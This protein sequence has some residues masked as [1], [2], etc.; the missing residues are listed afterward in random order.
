MVGS[1]ILEATKQRY[2]KASIF[3][4]DRKFLDLCSQSQVF[5][6]FKHNSFD[7]VIDC[8]AKVGG[9]HSNNKYR[10][11]F[12]YQNLQIQNNIIHACYLN[13]VKKLIFLGSSCVYPKN[14]PQPIKEESLLTSSLEYTNEPYA[15]AKIAGIKMCESYFKQYGCNF[16]SVMP[17]NLYGPKDSFHFENSHV[18]PS[19]MKKIHDA[20]VSNAESVSIWGTGKALREFMHVSDMAAACLDVAEKIDATY[21]NNHNISQINIGSGEEV[22]IAELVAKIAH[23]VGY[24]GKIIFDS[25]KPDG[26]P[27]KLLDCSRLNSIGFKS[28]INLDSGIKMTYDWFLVNKDKIRI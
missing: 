7:L 21:L 20:K 28:E 13:E 11:E 1:A 3:T 19:L 6:Y 22:S 14:A 12:I 5:S 16:V 23:C 8:A 27:K 4:I 9:I 26:T 15:V 10:A 18:L 2:P 24:N 17:T 25:S